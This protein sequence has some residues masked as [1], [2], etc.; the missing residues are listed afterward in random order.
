VNMDGYLL[1]A[2]VAF[3]IAAAVYTVLAANGM[4]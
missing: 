1:L 4:V 2:Y 3:A